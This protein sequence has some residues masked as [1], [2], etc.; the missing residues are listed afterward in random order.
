M[1]GLRRENPA[2]ASFAPIDE[3]PPV[4]PGESPF[5]IRGTGYLGHLAWVDQHFPGGRGA[6]LNL[7]SPPMRA[8]FSQTFLAI[9]MFDFLPLAAAG[10][11]CARALGMKFV[12]FIEMR[13]RHQAHV[14]IGGVYRMLLK[15]TS[16]RIVAGK[17]PAIMSKYF[18]F[19][20]VHLLSQEQ[21]CVRFENESVPH[22]LVEWFRGCY[23][24]YVEVVV[25]A[26]GGHLPTLDIETVPAPDFRGFAACRLVGIVRWS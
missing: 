11:V 22:I 26:A 4:P 17:L 8:F 3:T 6:F 10:R 23:T 15:M 18:D 12:D 25:G 14:D 9:S 7:L 20:A 19:G 13:G 1:I 16:P 24:G 2:V 5:H 21:H